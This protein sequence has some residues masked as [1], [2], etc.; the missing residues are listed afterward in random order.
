MFTIRL[1]RRLM[2]YD[3]TT[4][5]PAT[6]TMYMA[7]LLLI[8]HIVF[9]SFVFLQN[10]TQPYLETRNLGRQVLTVTHVLLEIIPEKG[11]RGQPDLAY[12]L[13]VVHFPLR[14]L[15]ALCETLTFHLFILHSEEQGLCLNK[16]YFCT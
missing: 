10:V 4:K 5:A 3:G 7:Q 9:F 11:K 1:Q 14:I 2:T 8:F 13:A 12:L 15:L 16:V 6:S